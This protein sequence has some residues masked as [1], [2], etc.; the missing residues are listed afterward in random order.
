MHVVAVLN[1]SLLALN[2]KQLGTMAKLSH[3]Y[4][5][6]SRIGSNGKWMHVDIYKF[7]DSRLLLRSPVMQNV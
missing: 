3:P 5:P 4:D 6:E 1:L 7:Y 2:P